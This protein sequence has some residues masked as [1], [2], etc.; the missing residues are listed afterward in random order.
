MA[1]AT[2]LLDV[3][4]LKVPVFLVEDLEEELFGV[5]QVGVGDEVDVVPG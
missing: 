2:T 1:A 5:V 4:P 3:L